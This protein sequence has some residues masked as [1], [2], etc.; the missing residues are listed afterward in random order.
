MKKYKSTQPESVLSSIK[1]EQPVSAKET[2]KQ[3]LLVKT[4]LKAGNPGAR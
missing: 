1:P 3:G 2:Q 4:G